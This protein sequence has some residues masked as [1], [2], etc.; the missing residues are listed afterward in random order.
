MNWGE[1]GK[2]ETGERRP[3]TGMFVV[4][5]KFRIKVERSKGMREKGYGKKCLKLTSLNS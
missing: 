1:K 5:L 4:R 3:E 2:T